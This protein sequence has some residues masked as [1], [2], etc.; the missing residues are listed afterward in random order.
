MKID[1]Y[2]DGILIGFTYYPAENV[3]DFN[4]V[5]LYILFIRITIWWT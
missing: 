4:E 2:F 1:I 5:N 3:N